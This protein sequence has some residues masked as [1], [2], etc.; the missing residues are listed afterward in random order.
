MSEKWAKL[1]SLNP[2]KK[3][4][5]TDL[6]ST[7][8]LKLLRDF[9]AVYKKYK[10]NIPEHVKYSADPI[11]EI[12]YPLYEKLYPLFLEKHCREAMK[13]GALFLMYFTSI[14]TA[15]RPARNL[16]LEWI[17]DNEPQLRKALT[18]EREIEDYRAPEKW[19]DNMKVLAKQKTEKLK[20]KGKIPDDTVSLEQSIFMDDLFFDRFKNKIENKEV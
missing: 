17:L 19:Y 12:I 1:E 13:D 10:G 3:T 9:R 2:I 20:K 16:F 5:L 7:S 18:K 11:L 8:L 6:R 14:D 15:Y 4:I